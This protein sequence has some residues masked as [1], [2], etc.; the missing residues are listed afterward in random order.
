MTTTTGPLPPLRFQPILKEKIWGGRSLERVL[1]RSLPPE[2][3][4]GESWEVSGYGSDRS[5]VSNGPLA[6]TELHQVMAD[7]GI[8]LVGRSGTG[9]VFPLLYKFIDAHDKLSVQVHPNDRQAREYEWDKRGKTECW[10]IVHAEPGTQIIVGFK[11]GVTKAAV[12]DAIREERLQE[13]L[14]YLDIQAGDVLLMPA[15]TVHAILGGTVIYEVQETS[16]ATLRLYDWG[17]VDSRGTSRPLHVEESLKVLDT[18]FHTEH[19]ITPLPIQDTENMRRRMRVACRYFALEEYLFRR[20]YMFTL[21]ARESF[22][23]ITVIEGA[24]TITTEH[25]QTHAGRG[26]TLLLPAALVETRVEGS[27]R[28]TA[29]VSWVPQL[30]TEIVEPLQR[31]GIDKER[32]AALGGHRTHNDLLPLL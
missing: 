15:G 27:E 32:I 9:E 31:V 19:K 3:Q 23:V 1:G 22:Q 16:D 28:T 25:G 10:Y 13:L 12:A 21:P 8:T 6:G 11:P 2:A 14:N 18:D 4:I 26:E 5:V 30:F 7:H 29:L 24:A 20:N 17:R